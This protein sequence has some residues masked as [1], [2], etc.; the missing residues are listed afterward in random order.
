MSRNTDTL[1]RA[2]VAAVPD[3]HEDFNTGSLYYTTTDADGEDW[4]VYA[5]PYYENEPG[6]SVQCVRIE[7]TD[8]SIVVNVDLGYLADK[9]YRA[10]DMAPA[11]AAYLAALPT[12][13]AVAAAV[14]ETHRRTA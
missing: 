1:H 2:I 10:G 9:A 11:L 7:D 5:T 4:D 12:I 8:C 14:I 13:K 3:M 6:V